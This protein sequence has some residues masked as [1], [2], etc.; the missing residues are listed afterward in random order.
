MVHRNILFVF[1]TTFVSRYMPE[2]IAPIFPKVDMGPHWRALEAKL[3]TFKEMKSNLLMLNNPGSN[4]GP[5]GG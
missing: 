1:Y 2:S 5:N 3:A 4:L